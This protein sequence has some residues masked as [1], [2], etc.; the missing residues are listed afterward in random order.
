MRK[1]FLGLMIALFVGSSF[2]MKAQTNMAGRTY[3]N[4]NI[5]ADIMQEAT[6]EIDKEMPKLKKE[7]IAKFEKKK[8]RKMTAKEEAGL[9]AE[10]KKQLA[11]LD[12]VK[13]GTKMSITVEFKDAKNL[14]LTQNTKISDEVL[15]AAGMGWFKR[16]ALKA[17]LAIAPKSQKCTYVVNGDMVVMSDSDNEKDT[18]FVSADGKF[19]S[20]TFDKKTKFKLTRTK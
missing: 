12:A 4:A 13:K 6:K 20:G 8:G 1:Y 5:F 7:A 2:T 11:T 17:A 16:K 14:V 10:I 9:D 3:H 19:L 15:K 18:M